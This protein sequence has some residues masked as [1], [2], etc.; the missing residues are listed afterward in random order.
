MPEFCVLTLNFECT[1]FE[2][3]MEMNVLVKTALNVYFLYIHIL[4]VKDNYSHAPQPLLKN[5]F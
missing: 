4:A 2:V 1:F 5:Y 3:L